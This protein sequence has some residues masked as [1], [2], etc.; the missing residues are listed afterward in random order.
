MNIDQPEEYIKKFIEFSKNP[1]GMML[2][3]G[4]NGTGKT[5]SAEAIF[6]NC[7]IPLHLEKLFYTQ[8]D[9]FFKWQKDQREWGSADYLYNRIQEA[10]LFVID[11]LGTR[12]P[13]DS[14]KDYLY[15]ILDKRYRNRHDRG[16]II[17]TNLNSEQLREMFGDAIVS[18]ICSHQLFKFDGKDRRLKNLQYNFQEF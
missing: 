5:F 16:T 8:A 2:L 12:T 15:A 17:T 3:A 9:L 1:C 7:H 14:F 10:K 4:K 6:N 13:S 11:D 18:R